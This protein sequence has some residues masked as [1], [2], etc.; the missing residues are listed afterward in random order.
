MI[1]VVEIGKIARNRHKILYLLD[2]CQSMGHVPLDVEEIGCDMLAVTGR[3]Y[4]RAPRGTGFLYVR[5][6]VQDKFETIVYG[7]L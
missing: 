6:E 3:K 1:P 7:W 2:A 4:L 5:K